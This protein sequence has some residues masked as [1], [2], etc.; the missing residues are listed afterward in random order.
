MK[1]S[2]VKSLLMSM[3][4]SENENIVNYLLGK[5]DMTD[6]SLIQE[7]VQ[8]VGGAE[9]SIRDFFERKISEVESRNHH[10]EHKPV[11][12]LITYG[13]AGNCIHLHLP[14][15][16]HEM[17]SEK[18]ILGTIN[19]VN[20]YLLDAI[21]RLNKQRQA[22]RF[23][24]KDSIYM[25]SPILLTKE[26]KFLKSLDFE[27]HTYKKSQLQDPDFLNS[28]SEAR[29]AVSIFGDDKTIGSAKLGFDKINSKEWQEKKKAAIS[30]INKKGITISEDSISK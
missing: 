12:E 22:G 15:D 27:T 13:I 7:A 25:I 2:E 11:N 23:Q 18:G 8:K 9:S 26:L 21:D 24:D 16:L 29:R 3:R 1:K 28:N 19:T 20:L 17:I 14:G 30:E 6:E 10:D 5:I 4:T